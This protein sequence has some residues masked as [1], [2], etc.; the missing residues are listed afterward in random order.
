MAEFGEHDIELWLCCDYALIVWNSWIVIIMW[1]LRYVYGIV[2]TN[3]VAKNVSLFCLVYVY[4]YN[5][6]IKRWVNA[7]E[8]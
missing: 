4:C 7:L 6:E 3:I 8:R 1:F 2:G 5:I